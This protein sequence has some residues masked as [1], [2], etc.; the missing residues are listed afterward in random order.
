MKAIAGSNN[1]N[2]GLIFL[3]IRFM[4]LYKLIVNKN[5][6]ALYQLNLYLYINTMNNI[7]DTLFI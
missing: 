2:A 3:S 6:Y 1:F 7:K 4:C 5:A